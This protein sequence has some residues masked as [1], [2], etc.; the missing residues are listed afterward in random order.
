MRHIL[1]ITLL[2]VLIAPARAT[3]PSA[4]QGDIWRK[5]RAAAGPGID[6]AETVRFLRHEG[7]AFDSLEL[8]EH[9]YEP[10]VK[11]Y[12]LQDIEPGCSVSIGGLLPIDVAEIK[13]FPFATRTHELTSIDFDVN[14]GLIGLYCS[15][16]IVKLS[17]EDAKQLVD[18]SNPRPAEIAEGPETLFDGLPLPRPNECAAVQN[19][20]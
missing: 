10:R 18:A 19:L 7:M 12:L 8:A 4:C 20:D 17:C 16:A 5:V 1:L 13:C 9:T 11:A 3:E 14:N 15:S 2:M 6:L